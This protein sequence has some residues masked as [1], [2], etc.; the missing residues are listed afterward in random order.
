MFPNVETFHY[1]ILYSHLLMSPLMSL[2]SLYWEALKL[3]VVGTG[4]LKS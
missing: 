3:M 2:K 1:T 4:F